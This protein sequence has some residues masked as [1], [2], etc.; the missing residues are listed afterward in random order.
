MLDVLCWIC[1]LIWSIMDCSS[2]IPFITG[3]ICELVV[4]LGR[5]LVSLMRYSSVSSSSMMEARL[6][7]FRA[8]SSSSC[9]VLRRFWILLRRV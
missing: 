2:E 4:K 3:E 6:S 5:I 8:F 9:S 1:F 7:S